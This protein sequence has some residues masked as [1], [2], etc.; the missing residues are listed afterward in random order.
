[1]GK[2]RWAVPIGALAS[3]MDLRGQF[4][5]DSVDKATLAPLV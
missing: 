5:I 2:G 1:M 4:P 3:T